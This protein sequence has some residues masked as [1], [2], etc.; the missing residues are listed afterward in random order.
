MPP[1]PPPAAGGPTVR[2]A[3]FSLSSA[4]LEHAQLGKAQPGLVPANLGLARKEGAASLC[5]SS[6]N[7]SDVSRP[8]SI[9]LFVVKYSL[10]ILHSPGLEMCFLL[11]LPTT[12]L[13]SCL[14]ELDHNVFWLLGRCPSFPAP[15]RPPAPREQA[16][17]L[18][19][20]LAPFC[21]G[22]G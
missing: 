12:A 14:Q 13:H 3:L 18:T 5:P 22:T 15:I 20:S 19:G 10:A 4:Q 21:G 9:D 7:P 11:W 6:Q 16:Q 2:M 1:Q 17:F 8:W